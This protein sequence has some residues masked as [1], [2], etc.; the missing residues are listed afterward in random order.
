MLGPIISAGASL[1]GGIFS[2]NSEA[3]MQKKFAQNAIQWKVADAK[4]AGVH[5]LFALGANTA[6]YSPT[7]VVGDSIARAGQDIGQAV[8]RMRTPPQRANAY[9]NLIMR[10]TVR[11]GEL[12]N[13]LLASKLARE[14]QTPTPSPPSVSGDPAVIPGQGD[15]RSPAVLVAGGGKRLPIGTPFGPVQPRADESPAQDFEDEYG[16]DG[17]PSWVIQTYRFARDADPQLKLW[18]SNQWQ[19]VL[20]N[21]PNELFYVNRKPLKGWSW[22]GRPPKNTTVIYKNR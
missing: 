7:N 1:L 5:P 18:L 16:E 14:A 8:D 13:A 20:R 3:K 11:R 12:E 2:R 22:Q 4:A 15:T 19:K 6:Q 10:N 21:Q 9:E 17:P